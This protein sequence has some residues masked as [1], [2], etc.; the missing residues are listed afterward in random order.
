MYLDQLPL[1]V[2]PLG[3]VLMRMMATER[4][5][6]IQELGQRAVQQARESQN[7][8]TLKLVEMLLAYRYPQLG[9]EELARMFTFSKEEMKQTKV[10]QEAKLEGKLEGKQEGKLESAVRLV[11]AGIPLSQVAQILEL[12]P[13]QIQQAQGSL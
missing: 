13:A 4:D 12:D 7:V 6:E 11:K 8:E 1:D 3:L 10:Y 5:P 9:A 2:Q